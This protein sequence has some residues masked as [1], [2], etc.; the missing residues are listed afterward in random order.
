M[1]TDKSEEGQH[2]GAHQH[3][4]PQQIIQ[5]YTW[6][7]RGLWVLTGVLYFL[8]ELD[9]F[10]FFILSILVFCFAVWLLPRCPNC[11][12]FMLFPSGDKTC[13]K[14]GVRLGD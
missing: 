6:R 10:F 1:S 5:E 13:K 8:G 14:C 4:T 9:G 2:P 3:K 11:E 7:H 12:V